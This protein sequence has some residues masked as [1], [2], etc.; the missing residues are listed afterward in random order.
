MYLQDS[1]SENSNEAVRDFSS[2]CIMEFLHWTLKEDNLSQ[3]LSISL[4]IIIKKI[5]S[6]C[7][8]SDPNKQL[9]KYYF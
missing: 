4:G 5:E 8:H 2:K 3:K 7:L 1:I 6:F 9:G